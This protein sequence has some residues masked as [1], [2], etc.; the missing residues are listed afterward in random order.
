MEK[1]RVEFQPFAGGSPSSD[2]VLQVVMIAEST[3]LQY[4]LANYGVQTQT[5]TEVEPVQIW[6][7]GE[8]VKVLTNMGRSH[9]LGINGRPTRPIGIENE[10]LNE[11]CASKSVY[12]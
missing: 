3:R 10:H 8:M 11:V 2:L 5:P 4:M 12:L 1:P 7:P 9:K 6:P